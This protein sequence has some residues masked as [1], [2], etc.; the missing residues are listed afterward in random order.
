M[1]VLFALAVVT[2]TVVS[3]RLGF[4]VIVGQFVTAAVGK[5]LLAVF[6]AALAPFVDYRLS[7]RRRWLS[8]S[9]LVAV[10]L[11]QLL[12]AVGVVE[13]DTAESIW[14]DVRRIDPM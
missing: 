8:P 3:L 7:E 10:G 1:A 9:H 12:V 6:G 13:S 11:A 14:T 2:A 4:G 5:S